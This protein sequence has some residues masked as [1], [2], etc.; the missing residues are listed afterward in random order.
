MYPT[1][2]DFSDYEASILGFQAF[3]FGPAVRKAHAKVKAVDL[4]ESRPTIAADRSQWPRH[5]WN[6]APGPLASELWS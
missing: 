3:N 5:P 2:N 1:R 4:A 6:I